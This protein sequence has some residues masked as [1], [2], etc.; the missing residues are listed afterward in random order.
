[1]KTLLA[2]ALAAVPAF[3]PA[4]T[5]YKSIGPNGEIVY[6]DQ[7]PPSGKVEKTFN[8]SNLPATPLPDAVVK[9]RNELQKSMEKRLAESGRPSSGHPVIFT[10]KWC[11]YCRQALAYLG[12]KKI[13]YTEHDIDTPGGMRAFAATG[14]SKGVPLLLVGERKVQGFSRPAYDSLFP[15]SGR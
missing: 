2:L 6:S 1:M 10:A 15:K 5:L 9:Y 7:P 14:A 12:E 8:F 3:A 11:G 4:A 13:G